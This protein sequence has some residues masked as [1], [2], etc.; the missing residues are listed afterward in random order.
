MAEFWWV[1]KEN[2]DEGSSPLRKNIFLF[3][4]PVCRASGMRRAWPGSILLSLDE[5][6]PFR[7]DVIRAEVRVWGQKPRGMLSRELWL[8]CPMK[9]G[10]QEGEGSPLGERV[11]VYRN[12]IAFVAK[13]FANCHV[14]VGERAHGRVLVT[15]V[16][17]ASLSICRKVVLS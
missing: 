1:F 6:S 14:S 10:R 5:L 17:A 15:A 12:H 4:L 9:R 11:I 2:Q 3:K 16:S 7:A 8:H 13:H